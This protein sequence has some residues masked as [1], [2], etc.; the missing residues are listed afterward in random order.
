MRNILLFSILLAIITASCIKDKNPPIPA[1]IF[2][3]SFELTNLDPISQGSANH[4]FRDVW[5]SV[6]G[7]IIGT[8]NIPTILP[9]MIADTS[10]TQVVKIYPGIE[11][12]GISSSR[13]VYPFMNP[14]EVNL[15]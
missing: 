7:Q 11:K 8:N 1:Y 9:T 14:Y 2:V 6:D 12:N 15:D 3:P 10:T 13:A 4:N 5:I